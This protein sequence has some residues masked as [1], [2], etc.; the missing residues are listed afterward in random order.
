MNNKECNDLKKIAK[1]LWELYCNLKL[2]E[3]DKLK[4]K[5]QELNKYLSFYGEGTDWEARI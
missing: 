1:E 5:I 3:V 2:S 4:L